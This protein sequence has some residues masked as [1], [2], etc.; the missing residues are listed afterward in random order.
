LWVGLIGGFVVSC[1]VSVFDYFV[2]S[3]AF[4]LFVVC[5]RMA[6]MCAVVSRVHGVNPFVVSVVGTFLST[7]LVVLLV[8]LTTSFGVMWAVLFAALTDLLASLMMG[9]FSLKYAIE[10]I[11]IS[12]F[13]WLGVYVAGKVSPIIMKLIQRS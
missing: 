12:L 5:P 13:V 4:A 11:I 1:F 3:L 2:V 7:P 10:I 9:V 8:Y 6:G